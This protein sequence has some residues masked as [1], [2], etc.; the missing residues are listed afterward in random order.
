L[1][2]TSLDKLASYKAEGDEDENYTDDEDD[3]E[4]E[5][6][7]DTTH[8]LCFLLFDSSKSSTKT[9]NSKAMWSLQNSEATQENSKR[10]RLMQRISRAMELAGRRSSL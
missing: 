6:D 3:D 8:C 2:Q 1:I 7:T 4:D 9:K 10:G 5:D